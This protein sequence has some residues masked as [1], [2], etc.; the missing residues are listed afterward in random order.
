MHGTKTSGCVTPWILLGCLATWGCRC[1]DEPPHPAAVEPASP[2]APAPE[3]RPAND[4][5]EGMFGCEQNRDCV[6]SCLHGAVNRAWYAAS[7]PGGEAC[8]DGCTSKGFEAPRC[9]DGICTAFRGGA[10]DPSCTRK[11]AE[12]VAGPGPAHACA[13][14]SDCMASCLYGAVN[15]GWYAASPR[16]R[17]ECKDGCAAAGLEV[18]CVQ[19]SCATFRGETIETAC[20]RRPIFT[21]D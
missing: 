19:G 21:T 3:P 1:G 5:P 2:P 13:V 14:D 7:Y 11:V 4:D 6:G 10:P 16:L 12:V 8:K 17:G 9:V 18:R 20:T 15:A